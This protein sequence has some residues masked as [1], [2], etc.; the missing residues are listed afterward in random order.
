[1]TGVADCIGD[2]RRRD[3]DGAAVF[4]F[5]LEDSGVAVAGEMEDVIGL[6]LK[7]G[8][9]L[10]EAAD[11]ED[12]HV[13]VA[14]GAGLFDGVEDGLQFALHVED[15]VAGLAFVG[16]ADGDEDFERAG[17]GGI[18]V[19]GDAGEAADHADSALECGGA[20]VGEASCLEWDGE[21]L[22]DSVSTMSSTVSLAA[23]ARVKQA[24]EGGFDVA[25]EEDAADGV[26]ELVEFVVSLTLRAAALWRAPGRREFRKP[27]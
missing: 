1:M 13:G 18:S 27:S 21:E 26:A 10:I 6:L 20:S 22:G 5:Q 4:V 15:G 14:E 19:G 12:A 9:D 7:G 2:I 23:L 11:V 25:M 17:L 24:G 3:W 8:P 16:R